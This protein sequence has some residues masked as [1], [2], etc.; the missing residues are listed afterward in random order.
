MNGSFWP[1]NA[2][3]AWYSLHVF[4]SLILILCRTNC[5]Y[6]YLEFYD[7]NGTNTTNLGKFCGSQFN[8]LTSSG[9]TL[10]L[11]FVTNANSFYRGFKLFY[12]FTDHISSK[13]L[14]DC[15]NII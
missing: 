15:Y 13:L 14:L 11:H 2:K 10:T 7:G 3:W 1:N 9:N 8:S 5:P 4:N 12:N 6:D